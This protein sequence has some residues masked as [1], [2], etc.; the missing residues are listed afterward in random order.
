MIHEQ[1]SICSFIIIFKWKGQ[2]SHLIC[3]RSIYVMHTA[4][5]FVNFEWKHSYWH[6]FFV[7]HSIYHTSQTHPIKSMAFI[8]ITA[9]TST[10]WIRRKKHSKIG[11][12]PK[13]NKRI[14]NEDDK[15]IRFECD[16]SYGSV[17]LYVLSV[18]IWY[19]YN[20]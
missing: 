6:H 5:I 4:K 13:K 3:I 18:R 15:N 12:S 2:Y 10:H 1:L 14:S 7:M 11:N 17:H 20:I 9:K 16:F 8:K 19:A